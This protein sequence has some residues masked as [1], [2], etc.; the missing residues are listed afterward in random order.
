LARYP[1]VEEKEEWRQCKQNRE[2]GDQRDQDQHSKSGHEEVENV[3]L[4]EEVTT[5]HPPTYEQ[6][7]RPK[8]CIEVVPRVSIEKIHG[9]GQLHWELEQ[10]HEVNVEGD[11]VEKWN[12]H[13]LFCSKE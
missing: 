2:E 3:G 13:D 11:I 12:G 9:N 4:S 1:I 10:C 7:V 8:S 5:E 6:E